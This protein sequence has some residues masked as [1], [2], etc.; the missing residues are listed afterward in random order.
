MTNGRNYGEEID[1]MAAELRELK[2][3][4]QQ[5]LAS[6]S[7]ANATQPVKD[8]LSSPTIKGQSSKDV[9]V[10]HYAGHY[11]SADGFAMWTP[12][13]RGIDQLL[14]VDSDKSA[15]II[16]AL[17]HKQ[18]LDILKAVIAKPMSG[19]ELVE[20]LQ[21]GT[22]GQLYHHTKALIGA[23]LLRQDERGGAYVVPAN[24]KLPLLLLLAAA[25]DLLD[26]SDYLA[27]AETR[28]QPERY[29][30]ISGQT[31]SYDPHQLLFAVM[32]NAI[33]EHKAGFCSSVNLFVH[34]DGSL[35]IADNGRGI[36]LW[37]ESMTGKP[38]AQAV[39]TDMS[40]SFLHRSTPHNSPGAEEG[41]DIPVVNAFCEA[42]SLE[43]R[44]DGSVYRQDYRHG[45]PQTELRQIGSTQETGTSMTLLPNTEL[46]AE[47]FDLAV[48]EAYVSQ[49]REAYPN[50]SIH[51]VTP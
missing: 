8:P 27:M 16:A 47:R 26:T 4:V 51:I 21:M 46:F 39:M 37:K 17:G 15:K 11:A 48:I 41:I 49:Q 9:N 32:E 6:D 20:H 30:G 33:L 28:A 7:L 14:Q 35:T 42:L 5:L 36:P 45:I 25:A 43:V 24:R 18:R 34:K 29:L 3:M 44:R 1:G 10:L 2:Q 40:T 31:S 19:P 13:Q 23:D 12:Q 38:V 50:L 22:T